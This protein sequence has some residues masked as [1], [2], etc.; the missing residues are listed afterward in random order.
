MDKNVLGTALKACCYAPKTGFYRDGFCK[1]GPEDVGTH[2]VCAIMTE[3]FLVYTKSQGNDLSTPI[4]MYQFPGLKPGDKWCLCASRWKQAYRA[5]KAPDVL[6]EATHEK[7][8]EII[9]FELLLEHK[10]S[11]DQP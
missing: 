11:E 8:L 2:V 5:G 6:L 7:A 10:Y 9:D 4:K 3:E 1:T